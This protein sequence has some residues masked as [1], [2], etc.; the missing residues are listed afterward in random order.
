MISCILTV[1]KH[2]SFAFMFY[3]LIQFTGFI[4]SAWD[5]AIRFA[6]SALG[7]CR[8]LHCN[9]Y[10]N[11][12]IQSEN[13]HFYLRLAFLMLPSESEVFICLTI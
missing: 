9:P 6:R 1:E 8:C 4:R 11:A 3:L 12:E 7:R 13:L 5:L 2:S 10:N